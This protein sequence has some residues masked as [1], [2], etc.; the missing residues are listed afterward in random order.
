MKEGIIDN[1]SAWILDICQKKWGGNVDITLL[2]YYNKKWFFVL[3]K[4]YKKT[5]Y[6]TSRPYEWSDI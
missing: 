2:S 5:K 1:F 6:Y 4:M 3:W